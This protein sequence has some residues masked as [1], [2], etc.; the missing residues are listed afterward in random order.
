M[1]RTSDTGVALIKDFEALALEAYLCP[2]GVSTIGWG[3]T[4]G[5]RL[6][7]TCTEA[8]ANTW[9]R[10]DLR[11]AEAAVERLVRVPLTDPQFAALVSWVFNVG[12]GAAAR[13]TLIRKLNTG[14]YDA[15]P[16][17]LA[18]WNRSR[19]TVLRGLV[20]RRAAEADLW[21][22]PAVPGPKPVPPIDTPDP[23]PRAVEGD[24]GK[25]LVRS[26]TVAGGVTASAGGAALLADSVGDA[27]EAVRQAEGHLSAGTVLGVVVAVLVIAGA[28]L[29]LYARWDDN[30]KGR[31]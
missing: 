3:H 15:V 22:T 8:Q 11:T 5:V 7:M 28:A 4:A 14:D 10:A 20:R 18:R 6:G 30:R 12:A 2:A 16:C 19:G 27:T 24:E 23:M 26:R 21:A 13:S 1:R 29:A 25:P 17:E 31:R 9:L